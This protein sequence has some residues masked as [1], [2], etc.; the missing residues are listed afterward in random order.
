MKKGLVEYAQKV[1]DEFDYGFDAEKFI[2]SFVDAGIIFF[3]DNIAKITLP[4]VQSYLLAGELHLNA[5]LAKEY[6]Q[7]EGEDFDYLTF[8]LYAEIGAADDMVVEAMDALESLIVESALD[9]DQQTILTGEIHPNLFKNPNRL[10]ALSRRVSAARSIVASGESDRREKAAVLDIADRVNDDVAEVAES[11]GNRDGGR[12][13]QPHLLKMLI[14]RW[15]LAT[16]LLG[17]GAESI[18]GDNRERLARLI[19]AGGEALIEAL[20]KHFQ[21]LDFESIKDKIIEDTEFR[22]NIGITDQ[23]DFES[24]VSAFVDFVE[25]VAY[26]QSLERVFSDLPNQAKHRIVGNSVQRVAVETKMQR[27]IRGV[28]LTNINER[29]GRKDMMSAIADL[30]NVQFLRAALTSILINRVKWDVPDHDTQMA[31]LDAAENLIRPYNPHL[32]KGEI[33]RLVEKKGRDDSDED[34]GEDAA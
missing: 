15:S 31:L 2:K 3:E 5:K 11:D 21:E 32:N 22:E 16:I 6:F 10:R 23:G 9:P 7:C 26:S 24:M 30:P 18:K 29:A 19:I 34:T 27:L 13:N 17:A 14:R 8:D 33:I 4:F 28:W 1:S 20:S 25:Y 12:K